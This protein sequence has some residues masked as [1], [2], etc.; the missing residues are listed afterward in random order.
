MISI[1]NVSKKEIFWKY[2]HA[3]EDVANYIGE[4]SLDGVRVQKL[5][6]KG[7]TIMEM[8]TLL[9]LT[10]KTMLNQ[11]RSNHILCAEH[12]T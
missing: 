2:E 11:A 4:T 10:S 1:P 8:L 5:G 3:I 12:T 6:K 9:E 7:F